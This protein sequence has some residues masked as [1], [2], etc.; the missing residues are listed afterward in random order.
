MGCNA[1]EKRD[2]FYEL[3]QAFKCQLRRHLRII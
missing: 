2:L 3:V 1:A